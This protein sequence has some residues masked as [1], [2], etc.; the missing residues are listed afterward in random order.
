M[1]KYLKCIFQSLRKFLEVSS[2]NILSAKSAENSS[3]ILILP[4]EE[5]RFNTIK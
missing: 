2:E 1:P 3:D 4:K 5:S